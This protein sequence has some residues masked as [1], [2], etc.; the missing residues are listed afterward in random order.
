MLVIART[1]IE[2]LMTK[3]ADTKFRREAER[4]SHDYQLACEILDAGKICHVGFTLEDQPYVV[5]MSYARMDDPTGLFIITRY[6]P[7]GFEPVDS[8]QPDPPLNRVCAPG[9]NH[10]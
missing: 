3:K 1:Y 4:G 7:A 10:E 2:T 5:P 6:K 8:V 9:P